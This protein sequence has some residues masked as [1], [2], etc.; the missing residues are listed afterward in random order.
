MPKDNSTKG[1]RLIFP[2]DFLE[3]RNLPENM[4]F[5]LRRLPVGAGYC[6]LSIKETECV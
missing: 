3:R 5:L 4:E 6:A 2:R 1:K